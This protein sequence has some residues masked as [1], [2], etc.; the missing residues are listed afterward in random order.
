MLRLTADRLLRPQALV[1]LAGAGL[2]LAGG[3]LTAAVSPFAGFGLLGGLAALAAVLVRPWL[4]VI[5]AVGVLYGL[6]FGVIPIELGSVRLTFLDAALTLTLLAWVLRLLTDPN[7]RLVTTPLA[8]PLVAFIGLAIT[9]FFVGVESVTGE[10]VRFFLKTI[11]ALLFYFTVVNCIRDAERLRWVVRALLVGGTFAALVALGL[12]ALPEGQAAELLNRLRVVGYP[13]GPDVIRHIAGT[14]IVRATGTAIDPNVLG[15]MLMLVAVTGVAQAFAPR[16]ALP[17]PVIW[18]QLVAIGA[19]LLLTFSRSAWLG[20]LAGV[21]FLGVLRFRWVWPAL[22]AAAAVIYLLPVGDVALERLQQGIQFEDP[23]AQM[24]LGEYRD[25]LRLVQRYPVFG[26]GFGEAPDIDV[27]VAAASVYLLIAGQM[28]LVGL[29]AFL[30]IIGVFAW[31]AII[32][33]LREGWASTEADG[34]RLATAGAVVAALSAGLF[35]H[36]FFNL[37][38]PQTI[39]LLWL[40]FGLA[41]A[42]ATGPVKVPEARQGDEGSRVPG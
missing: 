9:S 26:V 6:P 29:G 30:T 4:G 7:E 27:Y 19:A 20:T 22:A 8:L 23:A 3:I 11:N 5:A 17:R 24:R 42:S 2:A 18:G 39:S 32:R 33:P 41:M 12:Y 37:N 35:D 14:R 31:Q 13:T 1:P 40:F 10:V 34:Y 16:P 15:G 21:G 36:Y 28:G 38:F 25:A